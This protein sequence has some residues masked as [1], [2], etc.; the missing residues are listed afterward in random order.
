MP[1]IFSIISNF[2]FFIPV[3]ISTRRMSTALDTLTFVADL[4]ATPIELYHLALRRW[5]I[6][7]SSSV[8]AI[9]PV[10]AK[11][12]TVRATLITV[13]DDIPLR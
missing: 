9:T 11:P 7:T 10:S 3:N 12:I 1:L 5:Q 13:K 8:A 4:A 6:I 2:D